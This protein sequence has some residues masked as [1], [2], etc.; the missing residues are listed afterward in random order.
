[1]KLAIAVSK[2]RIAPLFDTS[3]R[4]LILDFEDGRPTSDQEIILPEGEGISRVATL[5]RLNIQTL[6]CG[7]ISQ[8]LSAPLESH[9]VRILAF[10]SGDIEHVVEAF[11]AGTLLCDAFCMPGCGRRRKRHRGGRSGDEP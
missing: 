9:G 11:H 10:V 6:I 2:E 5:V 7:A 4:V 1:M 3:R 8:E